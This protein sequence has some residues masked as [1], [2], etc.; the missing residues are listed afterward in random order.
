[1]ERGPIPEVGDGAQLATLFGL[2][3]QGVTHL[4]AFQR[5]VLADRTTAGFTLS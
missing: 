3:R 4:L 5:P 2:A 1:M